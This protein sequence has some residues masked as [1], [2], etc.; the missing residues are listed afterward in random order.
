MFVC[1]FVCLFV[2]LFIYLQLISTKANRKGYDGKKV[3]VWAIGVLLF[4][5]LCGMFPFDHIEH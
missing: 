2:Y 1:L 4:V 3:D 5:M